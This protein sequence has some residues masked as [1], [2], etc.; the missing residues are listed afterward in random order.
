MRTAV[1][2]DRLTLV[3][4]QGLVDVEATSKGAFSS[5]PMAAFEHWSALI[6]WA[7]A[8]D[9]STAILAMG[10]ID[11]P[12]VP[13]P[14]QVFGI[15]LNYRL[16]ALESGLPIPQTPLVFTKFPSSVAPA[17]GNV[18]LYTDSVDWEVEVAVVMGER[19]RDVGRE[20]AWGAI[21]GLTLA[22]DF[23]ARDVQL[24]PAGTPQ[25]SLGKSFAGFLPLGPLVATPD[26]FD[27]VADIH[28][29]C[30]I[31]G[32]RVQDGRTDD[33]VFPVP[34]L[35]EYLSSVV[36]LRPGDVVLTG[37]PSGVGFGRS[38]Q[39]FLR[40]GET[41]VT[42]MDVVGEMKHTAVEPGRPWRWT[43]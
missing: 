27:D 40:P 21:A 8:L 28:L 23:S 1:S 16:H 4:D 18:T 20:D 11:G 6:D 15:G 19:V 22:Q 37:T 10:E 14:S 38:P 39:R 25:F 42:G 30:E 31:D 17:R 9:L 7:S 24:T 34:V 35:I 43:A 12:A 36:E 41:V 13:A 5:D 29:W 2:N 32:E 26:E 33:L 3:T